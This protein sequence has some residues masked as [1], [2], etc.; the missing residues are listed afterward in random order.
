ML[1]GCHFAVS[2][3]NFVMSILCGVSGSVIATSSVPVLLELTGVFAHHLRQYPET[4]Q[5][6]C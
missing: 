2:G 5:H 3:R 4:G 6:L 1:L